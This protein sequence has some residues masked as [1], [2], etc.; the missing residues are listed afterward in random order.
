[1]YGPGDPQTQLA[2][3][4]ADNLIWDRYTL[5]SDSRPP[6]IASALSRI[7]FS[8][9]ASAKP[10]HAVIDLVSAEVKG[11]VN[12]GRTVVTVVGRSRR[13]AV[14]SHKVELREMNAKRGLAMGPEVSKTV[15]DVGAAVILAESDTSVLVLQARS[16]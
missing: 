6:T 10:L 1:V 8:R 11:H 16:G 3:E 13:L 15:G 4:T 7:T 9:E 5:P 14:E 2:S 12:S